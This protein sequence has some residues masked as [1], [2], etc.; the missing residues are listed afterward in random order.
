MS[1]RGTWPQRFLDLAAVVG[2]WSKD[3]SSKVG[4]VAVESH[5]RTILATGFNGLP[6]G[7]AD[8]DERMERPAKYVWTAHAEES[9]VCNA[10][11]RT[12]EGSTVYVTHLCCNACM[13]M[14]INS[15]VAEVVCGGG[16]TSMP[17]ELFEAALKMAEEAG[18][19]VFL[20]E[21]FG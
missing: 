21:P 12:L 14:L 8:I 17:K 7:V 11:R 3:K 9:L 16:E 18:V 19:R 13:R 1:W 5:S 2:G 6:R 20:N 15:G 10:A 4:A